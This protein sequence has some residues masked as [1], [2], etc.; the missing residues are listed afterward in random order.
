MALFS[1]LSLVYTSPLSFS[2]SSSA[3]FSSSSPASNR[4]SVDIPTSPLSP[5]SCPKTGR[6]GRA[7]HHLSSPSNG[8]LWPLSKQLQSHLR[9]SGSHLS[10]SSAPCNQ[11][12]R[13]AGGFGFQIAC[14][15]A[16][17]AR[18]ARGANRP[19]EKY[20]AEVHCTASGRRTQAQEELES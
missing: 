12:N 10:S 20:A 7:Q 16:D 2:A 9:A 4:S 8:A 5:G 19:S 14:R 13:S 3:S 18:L 17:R 11:R 6:V 1:A 15:A